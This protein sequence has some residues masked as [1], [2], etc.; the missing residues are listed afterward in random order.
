MATMIDEVEHQPQLETRIR[1]YDTNPVF[2]SGSDGLVQLGVLVMIEDAPV[3]IDEFVAPTPS[4][5]LVTLFRRYCVCDERSGHAV[6]GIDLQ[7]DRSVVQIQHPGEV[8]RL[9]PRAFR[10]HTY[11]T[12]DWGRT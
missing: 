10:M 5:G 6:T 12:A 9:G 2:K 1:R 7:H 11:N 3:F 8:F 4:V